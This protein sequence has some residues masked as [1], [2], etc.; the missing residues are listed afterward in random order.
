MDDLVSRV[1]VRA[2]HQWAPVGEGRAHRLDGALA[3]CPDAS[4]EGGDGHDWR[5]CEL[6][7]LAA[8]SSQAAYLASLE[9]AVS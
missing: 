3:W 8:V 9:S 1:C 6:S 2:D 7:P 4:L 5:D